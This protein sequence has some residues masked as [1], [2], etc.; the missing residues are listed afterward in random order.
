MRI[1]E[2]GAVAVAVG[3]QTAPQSNLSERDEVHAREQPAGDE[4]A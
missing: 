3:L 4:S 2:L 1:G